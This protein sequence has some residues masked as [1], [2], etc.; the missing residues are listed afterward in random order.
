[1]NKKKK[2][3]IIISIVLIIIIGG[4][5]GVICAKSSKTELSVKV[6]EVLDSISGYGY[7]L[8]DRDTEIYKEKY[9]ELKSVLEKDEIDYNEYAKLLSEL[10]VIDL[11]TIDNKNNK[12][13]VGSLDFIY[14]EDQDDF[15]NNVLDT[16]Y[17]LVE[18][19]TNNDRNQELPVVSNTNVTNIKSTKYQKDDVNLEA[20]LVNVEITYEKDLGYDKEVKVTV[21]KE[22]NKLYVVSSTVE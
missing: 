4:I 11:Y 14:Y 8:E 3:L 18:D 13:D 7:N 20:Y 21:V 1:M 17:K 19:N 2:A 16:M 22:D 9:L 15:K 5:V 10:F 12:Y 6:V